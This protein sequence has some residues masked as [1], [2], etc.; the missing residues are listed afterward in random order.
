M[1]LTHPAESHPALTDRLT[2]LPNRL[3][4]DTVLRTL[5]PTGRR[6]LSL[7]VLIL[8]IDAAEEWLKNTDGTEVDKILRIVGATMSRLI[9]ESDVLARAGECQFAICLMDCNMAG[10]VLVADRIDGLLDPVRD[11]HDLGF[12]IGGASF[13]LDMGEAQ[14]LFG[15]AEASLRV[16]QAKG[17]N[18]VEIGR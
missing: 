3:H 10:A 2:G 18:Q 9:R 6:G 17:M 13:D 8:E 5:F 11:S 1:S 15:A 14:D 12:S 16:A 7:S 4:F